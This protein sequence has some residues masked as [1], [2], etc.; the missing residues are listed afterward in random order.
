MSGPEGDGG[1]VTLRLPVERDGCS[2]PGPLL[3]VDPAVPELRVEPG[4]GR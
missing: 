2:A 4:P 1:A 3:E